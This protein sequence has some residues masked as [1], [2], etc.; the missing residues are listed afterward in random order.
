MILEI[1]NIY[2]SHN[3]SYSQNFLISIAG[4]PLAIGLGWG[5]IIY[6]AM[7]LSDQYNIPWKIRP[8]MDALTAVVLD[9]A[10][11]PV[12]IRLGFWNWKMPLGNEWY[13]VPFENLAGW[14]FVTLSFSF[15][16]RFI[17][18][19]NYKRFFTKLLMIFSPIISYVLS[20]LGLFIFSI[21]AIIPYQINDWKSI[22]SLIYNPPNLSILYNPHVQLWKLI[23]LIIILTEF[24]HIVA[25]NIIKYRKNYLK[26]FDIVSFISLTG[27][28][29]IFLTAL[30]STNLYIELPILLVIS[31]IALSIHLLLHLLPYIINRKTIYFFNIVKEVAEKDESKLNTI[32][33]S[34]FK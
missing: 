22:F 28:H 5:V 32:I 13:G 12:A 4:V 8:F 3:Y 11:D 9:I 21:I 30:I 14:I 19:L 26:N 34:T 17:R 20:M 7:L 31:I 15:V 6:S 10:I 25:F 2:F 23:I 29:L 1:A 18:T 33:N 16:I 27:I 24:V